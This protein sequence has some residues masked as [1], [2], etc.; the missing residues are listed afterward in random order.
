MFVTVL[1]A[2]RAAP[3]SV[4]WQSSPVLANETLLI[5]GAGLEGASARLCHNGV[6]CSDVQAATWAQSVQVVL[7][8]SCGPPC[9]INLTTEAGSAVVTVNQPEVWWAMRAG[10]AAEPLSPPAPDLTRAATIIFGQTLRV[11]G[12]ALA[13][14]NAS[15]CTPASA[16]MAAPSTKLLLA[17]RE[18]GSAVAASCYEASFDSSTFNMSNLQWHGAATVLTPWGSSQ[19]FETSHRSKAILPTKAAQRVAGGT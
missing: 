10:P 19:P 11:F 5:A 4:Y 7:P 13:W 14:L 12:R 9:T 16:P 18:L 3:P 17:G 6:V 15:A 8:T 1:A 2:V